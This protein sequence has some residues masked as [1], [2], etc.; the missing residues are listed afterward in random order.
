MADLPEVTPDDVTTLIPDASEVAEIGRGG[1]KLVFRAKLSDTVYAIKFAKIPDE[2]TD[3]ADLDEFEGTEVAIRAK[4]EVETMRNS[5]SPHL[6]RIGPV[7]LNYAALNGKNVLYFSEQLIEGSDLRTALRSDGP[8]SPDDVRR[9]GVEGALAIQSMARLG[10]VHRDIK[11][12]N[13]MR[14]DSDGSFIILDAGLAF[15][16]AAE[17]ISV[18]PVGT[19]PYFSPEQFDFANRRIVLDFRSDLFSLGVT[20]Y[21]MASGNHPFFNQ[22]DTQST[23]VNNILTHTPDS[24]ADIVTDFPENLGDI[25]QRLLGKRPHVRY[26]NCEQ[27]LKALRNEN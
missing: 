25:V 8:F 4:R 5:D 18:G 16:A 21:E 14:R 23:V 9:L 3:D 11:P 26:R 6:V 2:A 24:L 1:Q 20:M 27:L 15:D 12:A 7:G 17:S 13:I 22:G 10:K 19:L